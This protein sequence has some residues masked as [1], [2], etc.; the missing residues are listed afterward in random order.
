MGIIR[1]LQKQITREDYTS[2]TR[3]TLQL[4]NN[5][6]GDMQLTWPQIAE[7]HKRYIKIAPREHGKSITLGQTYPLW[8]LHQNPELKIKN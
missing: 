5:I 3:H 6:I 8:K 2:F 4:P 1:E 7:K